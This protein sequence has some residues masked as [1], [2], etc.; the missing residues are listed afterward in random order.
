[1][2]VKKTVPLTHPKLGEA[3]LDAVGKVFASG[4]LV[5]GPWVERFED[6]VERKIGVPHAVAV[7][8]GTSA[9]VLALKVLNVSHGAEVICPDLTWP[10]PAHAIRLIGA[11]PVLID[12]CGETWNALPQSYADAITERTAAAIV[13]HQFGAPARID[14]IR[15]VLKDIP[16]IEDA[17][18]AIGS[19]YQD[20][21]CGTFG[22]IACFSFHPRKVITTGEGGMCLT[23]NETWAERLRRLR[24]HGQSA[25]GVFIEPADNYRMSELHA[26]V[27]CAQLERLD[28][29]VEERRRRTL[30]YQTELKE[31]TWQ[32]ILPEAKSNFQTLGI[33][34][35]E[36]ANRDAWVSAMAQEGIE[37]GRL[38]YA[39]H[40]LPSVVDPASTSDADFPRSAS[41]TDHG[42]ALPL[43]EN[44]SDEEQEYVLRAIKTTAKYMN[45]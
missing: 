43:Y 27:G 16:I 10:S 37:V 5:Q 30:I 8:S 4:R 35:S 2:T 29:M 28:A 1:M 12:V 34:L 32:K 6:L 18:C 9:L 24:N 44:F 23:K 15:D 45:P 42:V 25:P 21:P 17:A 33:S 11:K 41:L 3:E 22:E 38:S 40:R 26:A 13:I 20:Q 7:S 39:L 19:A 36:G 31:M 14:G